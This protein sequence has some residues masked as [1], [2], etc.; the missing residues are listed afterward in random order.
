[1]R[2]S[3]TSATV[4]EPEGA[5]AAGATARRNARSR[6]ESIGIR[7]CRFRTARLVFS[8]RSA[9]S[10][11]LRE[12]TASLAEAQGAKAGRGADVATVS[13]E[14]ALRR[15]SASRDYWIAACA[16]TVAGELGLAALM[17][18]IESLRKHPGAIVREAALRASTLAQ[19]GTRVT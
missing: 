18:Q 15:L 12:A 8:G 17:P 2:P 10:G 1:M 6:P 3:V 11:R 5:P 9:R 13:F 4:A 7:R 16:V 19:N 14:E